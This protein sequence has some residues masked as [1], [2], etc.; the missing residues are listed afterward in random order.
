MA[1]GA[2]KKTQGKGMRLSFRT[3]PECSLTSSKAKVQTTHDQQNSRQNMQTMKLIATSQ[4]AVS[5]QMTDCVG[6]CDWLTWL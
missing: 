5:I 4:S 3:T 2:G 1:K 6:Y